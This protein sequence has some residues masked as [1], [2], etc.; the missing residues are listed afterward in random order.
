MAHHKT[1]KVDHLCVDR[2]KCEMNKKYI[3][4][5]KTFS[6]IQIKSQ[7]NKKKY[8]RLLYTKFIRLN[9]NTVL[10]NLFVLN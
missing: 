9:Y 3:Q 7:L 1:G 4:L 6:F 8:I 5:K 2:A 10:F